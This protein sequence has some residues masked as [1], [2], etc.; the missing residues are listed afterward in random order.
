MFI[1]HLRIVEV[2]DAYVCGRVRLL[3]DDNDDDDDADAS[4]VFYSLLLM[5]VLYSSINRGVLQTLVRMMNSSR[6]VDGHSDCV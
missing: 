5:M 3:N 4:S 2:T 6:L 1:C